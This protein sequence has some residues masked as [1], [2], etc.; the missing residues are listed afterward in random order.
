MLVEP[1]I[2]GADACLLAN[3]LQQSNVYFGRE[4]SKTTEITITALGAA[5]LVMDGVFQ[6][7]TLPRDIDIVLIEADKPFGYDHVFPLGLLR[8]PLIGLQLFHYIVLTKVDQVAPSI[9]SGIRKP[10]SLL[11]P[12]IPIYETPPKPPFMFTLYGLANGTAGVPVDSYIDPSIMA[13]SGISNPHSFSQT[14]AGVGYHVVHALPFGA[15]HDGSTAGV[16]DLWTEAFFHPADAVCIPH[17]DA[18]KLSQWHA[19]E[20]LKIP[21]QVL[22]IGCVFISGNHEGIENLEI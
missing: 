12:H 18:L 9:V 13:V 14:L 16:V 2:S 20:D 15:D 8:E 6:H 5:C 22:S 3:V 19:N 1:T 4:R 21:I 11:V 7:R 17:K 10:L